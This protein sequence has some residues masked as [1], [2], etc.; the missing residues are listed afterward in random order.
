MLDKEKGRKFLKLL[1]K[2]L[3]A[4]VAAVIL[5][6]TIFAAKF[7]YDFFVNGLFGDGSTSG[8]VGDVLDIPDPTEPEATLPTEPEAVTVTARATVT[9][10]GD[11][12]M[13]IPVINSGKESDGSYNFDPTFEMIKDYVNQ[14]DYSAVNLETTLGGTDNGREY[15]GYPKF[16]CPDEIADAVKNA[17]FD[18]FLT[19][20]NH[21]NDSGAAG[22][23]RTFSTITAR[24]LSILGT[25]AAEEDP[26]Y[27]VVD[28]GGI[29]VGMVCYTYGELSGSGGRP[30]VNGLPLDNSVSSLIN[31]FDYS[32]LD[33]F[34]TQM[35]SHIAAMREAGAEAIV[36]FIHWGEEY[37][38]S[39]NEYQKTIAQKMC[40]LGVDV[41]AGGHPH[42]VQPVTLLT[43]TADP[44]H[45]TVCV[46][47]VGN[48]LSN[49][50]S[51]NVGVSSGH[52][53]DGALFTF[54]FVKYS[55]GQVHLDSADILPTWVQM[56]K[57][58]GHKEYRVLPLDASVTDWKT[59]LG[60]DDST[61][62]S[63]KASY[64]RTMA[65]VGEGLSGVQTALDQARTQREAEFG[66]TDEGVG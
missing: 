15:S 59:A 29:Q 27:Q 18:M 57:E 2:I 31:I 35:E 8:F 9:V 32:H 43:S 56:W 13:H 41:I 40:D 58:D 39:P 6:A 64:D 45:Q 38:L 28:V 19:A 3:L 48:L 66:I 20:N 61:L 52:T 21:A 5:G 26:H 62:S 42:V 16:N 51:D 12:M 10:A 33:V 37:Q 50:R 63:A 1:P 49:Q 17:G 54:S 60:I 30:A 25:V 7:C 4:I 55:N 65:I 44:A 36:L 23:K 24:G 22:M 34:Y 53:E 11:V 47:S 14:A 46:Y